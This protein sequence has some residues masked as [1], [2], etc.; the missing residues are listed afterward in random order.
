MKAA[1]LVEVDVPDTD[2]LGQADEI[3]EACTAK[4]IAVISVKPWRH[5]TLDL[6]NPLGAAA[7]LGSSSPQTPP[8]APA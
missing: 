8:V 7:V 2:L 4:D 6:P 3:Y 1:F 5:P